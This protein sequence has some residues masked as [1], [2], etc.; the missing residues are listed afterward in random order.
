[1]K[2]DEDMLYAFSG[3]GYSRRRAP[4]VSAEGRGGAW[5]WAEPG[6]IGGGEGEDGEVGDEAVPRIGESS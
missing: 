1:M 5:L 6:W 3:R 4:R 2:D